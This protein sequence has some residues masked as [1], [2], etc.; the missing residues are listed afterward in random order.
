MLGVLTALPLSDEVEAFLELS[1]PLIH[2]AQCDVT[3]VI[4]LIDEQQPN[5]G[6]RLG[7]Y[8]VY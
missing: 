2:T 1:D 5:S 6:G 3:P 7:G 4:M 8:E